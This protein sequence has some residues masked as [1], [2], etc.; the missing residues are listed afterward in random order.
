MKKIE[1]EAKRS[2]RLTKIISENAAGYGYGAIAQA[3]RK[4]DALVNGERVKSDITVSVGDQIVV[5]LPDKAPFKPTV[6]YEDDDLVIYDKPTGIEVCDGDY[7]MVAELKAAG[8]TVIP[9]HRLDRN[10]EGLIV[11][12]KTE[13]A[14]AE[15]RRGFSKG[16]AV[17][18]YQAE[19]YGAPRSPSGEFTDYVVKN[20]Q[21]SEVRVFDSPVPHGERA[22]T[23]YS[24]IRTSGKVSLLSVAISEGKTHQ[25]RACLA[26]HGLP[27]IGDGKYGK[28]EINKLYKAKTQR[29]RCYAIDFNFDN[30]S[31]LKQL[32]DKKIKIP[33]KEW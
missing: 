30:D 20:A 2:G 12:A 19:V 25:I 9:V 7:N 22:V 24:L 27:I 10:T 18:H 14:A 32:R 8:V 16:G 13:H 11:F 3:V 33:L 4:K 6:A 31:A 21:K 5:Y 17:K 23:R 15:L 26:H 28:N 1:F 29:L